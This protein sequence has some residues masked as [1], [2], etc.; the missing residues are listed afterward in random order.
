MRRIIAL[1][2]AL[3]LTVTAIG[4]FARAPSAQ[5]A[6]GP[7][8][9]CAPGKGEISAAAL[10]DRASAERCDTNGRQIVDGP[11]GTV[12]PSP[13]EGIYVE[14]LTP[15]GAQELEVRHLEDGTIELEHVG[16]EGRV[17]TES[18]AAEQ[19]AEPEVAARA[20]GEC[21]DSAYQSN[22]RRIA[23]N[24]EYR[25][26][27]RTTPKELSRPAAVGAIRKAGSNV[28]NTVNRCRLGDRVP[29]A[30]VYRGFSG[31]SAGV[32]PAGGCARDDRLS[33]AS[34]GRVRSGV[35]AVTCD[36]YTVKPGP[37]NN[38]VNSTD[39]KI[40]SA[41]FR[42]TTRPQSRSCKKE[43]AYDLETLVTHERGHSFGLN[44]V[45]E[46]AHPSLTMGPIINGPCQSS[47]R[48]LGRG[49]VLG[50]DRKYP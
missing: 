3:T 8:E 22:G 2:A 17:A 15:E 30:L 33:V 6:D 12:L 27:W 32:I 45:S 25:I 47:E 42:W 35:L 11:V 20:A 9:A 28:F 10:P 21:G 39:L 44:H 29:V 41:N 5:T 26:N 46:R 38:P 16:D 13:G 36:Y 43:R 24:L 14:A 48:T 37:N 1:A 49:D 7:P 4:L 19:A 34:F 31:R 18:E 40:N 23:T 50:L